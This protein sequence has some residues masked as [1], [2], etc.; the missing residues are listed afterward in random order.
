MTPYFGRLAMKGRSE[1]VRSA[2]RIPLWP[3]N[4][5]VEVRNAAKRRTLPAR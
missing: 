1:R 4:M 5:G 3:N 2:V